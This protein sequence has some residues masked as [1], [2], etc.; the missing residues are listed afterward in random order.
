[1]Y[2]KYMTMVKVHSQQSRKTICEDYSVVL[3]YYA[4]GTIGTP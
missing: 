1:V 4:Q 3:K 2:T